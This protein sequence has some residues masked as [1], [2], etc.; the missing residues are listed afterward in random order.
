MFLG[1]IVIFFAVVNYVKL[2][3]Y[4]WLGLLDTSNLLTSLSLV[5]LAPLGV[6]LGMR[7]HRRLDETWFYRCCYV[8]L[9][10]TGGQLC[11]EGT[12][13]LLDRIPG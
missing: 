2:V 5:L 8:L 1:T 13:E 9:L 4:A 12:V 3:P 10:L 11:Y 7:L 6:Y